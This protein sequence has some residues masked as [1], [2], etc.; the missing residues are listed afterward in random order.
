MSATSTAPNR[1]RLPPSGARSPSASAR[2]NPAGERRSSSPTIRSPAGSPTQARVPAHELLR[3][4]VQ[5]EAELVLEAHGPKKPQRVVLED[6]LRDGAQSPRLD[7]CPPSERVDVVASGHRL[8][9]RVDR[10]VA[11]A[12]VVLDRSAERREVD[13]RAV[14]ESDAPGAVL[15]GERE[16]RALR[17]TRVDACGDLGIGRGDIDVH[18]LPAEELVAHR[19]SHE[20]RLDPCDC[21]ADAAI[22]RRP[23][24][25]PGAGR[26]PCRS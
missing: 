14:L 21:R 18:D 26:R 23:A 11:G 19:A 8:R 15:L 5:R 3:G 13:R 22:H 7:V 20:V 1:S 12:E 24:F 16:D 10:E 6:R 9:D 17:K 2:S 25:P 4:L